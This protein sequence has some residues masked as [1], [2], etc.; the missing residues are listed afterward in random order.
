MANLIEGGK[1][2]PRYDK[3]NYVNIVFLAWICFMAGGYS[4]NL[5]T[6]LS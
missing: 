1:E 6:M 2:R 5:P 3:H 4:E